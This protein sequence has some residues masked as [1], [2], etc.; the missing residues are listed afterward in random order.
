MTDVLARREPSGRTR[1]GFSSGVHHVVRLDSGLPDPLALELKRS[2]QVL[3]DGENDVSPADKKILPELEMVVVYVAGASCLL[4]EHDFARSCLRT[5]ECS[6]GPRVC[7]PPL[8]IVGR[9]TLPEDVANLS[10]DLAPCYHP[11][12]SVA[13][14]G[15][16]Q[17]LWAVWTV[18]TSGS[19]TKKL[20]HSDDSAARR[21]TSDVTG[22]IHVA[23]G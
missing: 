18:W 21:R 3:L 9:L 11:F 16:V 5:W 20:W 4:N 12:Q 13:K 1:C 7:A 14:S 2:A 10:S 8:L 22:R 17:G 23:A 6:G 19:R 15:A